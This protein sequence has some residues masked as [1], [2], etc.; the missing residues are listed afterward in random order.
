MGPPK[1]K[2]VDELIKV[3]WTHNTSITRSTKFTLFKLLY[4]EEVMTPKEI[5]Y[6]G[7]IAN[8]QAVNKD[9]SITKDLFIQERMQSIQNLKTYKTNKVM[10]QQITTKT[11]I[12]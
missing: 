1:G 10:V 11:T 7:P 6:K 12:T 4:E 2:W 8:V 9:H 3:V 5:K